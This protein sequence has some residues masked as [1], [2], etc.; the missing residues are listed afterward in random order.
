MTRER[1]YKHALMVLFLLCG[2]RKSQSNLFI[3][4][5]IFLFVCLSFFLYLS[6]QV[7]R[8]RLGGLDAAQHADRAS[9][10][11]VAALSPRSGSSQRALD[12]GHGVPLRAVQPPVRRRRRRRRR[13][14]K[15]K[16]KEMKEEKTIT[17]VIPLPLFFSFS[18][19]FFFFLFFSFFFLFPSSFKGI[20]C[21]V[22]GSR[23]TRTSMVWTRIL[24]SVAKLKPRILPSN[25][26]AVA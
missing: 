11:N 5:C 24:W 20:F 16:E 13:R 19:F 6:S 12:R 17:Y 8:A 21:D 25:A 2:P 9:Q 23:V 4:L 3:Y 15:E 1:F 18:L 14:R 7:E 10:A 26:T 22:G